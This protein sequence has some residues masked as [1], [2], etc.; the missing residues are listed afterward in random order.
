MASL[1]R[2][3]LNTELKVGEVSD[4]G[5]VGEVCKDIKLGDVG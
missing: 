3:A 4:E 1:G 5:K 2:W